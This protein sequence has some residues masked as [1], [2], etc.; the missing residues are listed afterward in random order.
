MDIAHY[1]RSEALAQQVAPSWRHAE[2]HR[3]HVFLERGFPVRVDSSADLFQLLD[4]MQEA[5]F[6]AYQRELGGL[7]ADDVDV[8]VDAFCAYCRFFARHF[9]ANRCVLPLATML[10]HY[11]LYTKLRRWPRHA[12]ILEIGPGCGYLTFFLRRHPGLASYAQTENT[13][14]FYMLQNLVADHCFGA[15]F[16]EHAAID[17]TAMRSLAMPALFVLADTS[18]EVVMPSQARCHHWPW[19]RIGELAAL[20]FDLV[21]SNANLNE[22]SH[23]AVRHYTQ[24]IGTALRPDGAVVV[25]D[26]G[27]GPLPW[28]AIADCFKEAGLSLALIYDKGPD[29]IPGRTLTTPNV[30]FTRAGAADM[31]AAKRLFEVPSVPRRLYSGA[32]LGALVTARLRAGDGA[33]TGSVA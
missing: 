9:H 18:T 28:S 17:P 31:A 8:V 12:D 20:R 21:T 22:M 16:V 19:W 3:P 2:A 30:V 23:R 27:G 6:E 32:E 14:S 5:R 26:P 29:A 33:A 15:A 11:V 4:T 13:E 10:A 25:Q 24:I 1:R 7:S